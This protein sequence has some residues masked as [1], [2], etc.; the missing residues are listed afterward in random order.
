MG[1]AGWSSAWG[2]DSTFQAVLG[3]PWPLAL[4]AVPGAGHHLGGM[5][6]SPNVITDFSAET[7]CAASNRVWWSRPQVSKTGVQKP[8]GWHG[9]GLGTVQQS[10][11]GW[12]VPWSAV[13][14][15]SLL[16]GLWRKASKPKTKKK[17]QKGTKATFLRRQST[18]QVGQVLQPCHV[19]AYP[20]P[21]LVNISPSQGPGRMQEMG[22]ALRLC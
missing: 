7:V 12:T 3:D 16:L 18:L 14:E 5:V 19:W 10:D 11:G 9:G 21:Q 17:E 6:A 22:T 2:L 8:G 15:G 13:V 4:L 1:Y 20:D